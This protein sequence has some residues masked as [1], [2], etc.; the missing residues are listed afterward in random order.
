MRG[1]ENDHQEHEGHRHFC[2]EPRAERVAP[3]R[4]L[5]IAV[6][7][8]PARELEA[9]LAAGNQIKERGCRDRTHDLRDDVRRDFGPA[10]AAAPPVADRTPRVGMAAREMS[11]CAF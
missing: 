8:E 11:D 10:E 1:P 5:A 2:D 3:G 4:M 9:R 7:A 6:R